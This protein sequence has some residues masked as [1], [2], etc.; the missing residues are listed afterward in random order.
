MTTNLSNSREKRGTFAQLA[1]SPLRTPVGCPP[2]RYPVKQKVVE[3]LRIVLPE[4]Q[5][6]LICVQGIHFR[7]LAFARLIQD[8]DF[9]NVLV[10][11]T[12]RRAIVWLNALC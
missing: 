6:F 4:E 3:S 2:S 10:Q 8:T 1:S 11:S 12:G 5:A 9:V 7:S